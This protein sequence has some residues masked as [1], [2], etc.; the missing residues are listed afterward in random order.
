M[1]RCGPEGGDDQRRRNQSI[2]SIEVDVPVTFTNRSGQTLYRGLCQPLAP[3]PWTL[4][5]WRGAFRVACALVGGIHP[6]SIPAGAT[7]TD[8]VRL[9][10]WRRPRRYPRF[11]VDPIP[12]T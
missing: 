8:T 9:G 5:G 6:D 10:S 12:G 3:E 11:E 2:V 1:D 7:V 4:R